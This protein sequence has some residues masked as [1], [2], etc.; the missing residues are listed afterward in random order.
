MINEEYYLKI[1]NNWDRLAKPLDS[2]G[3]FEEILSKI[4]GILRDETISISP[5]ALIVFIAD[6]GIINQGVSQS[7]EKVT[8][9]VARSIGSG[10]S[11]VCFMSQNANINVY[12]FNIGMKENVQI[13]G[14]DN[15][16]FIRNGTND[17]S[18]EPA[19]S[20]DELNK[21]INNGRLI[22]RSLKD[23]GYRVLL[24]G[25][26]GIGNTTTS[27][28]VISALLHMDAKEICGR[29]AG[30]SDNGLMAK[31][32]VINDA[33]ASYDLFEASG[34]DV[35]RTVGGLDIAAMVGVILE[36]IE[37]EIPVILDG[38]ITAAAALIADSID[39]R[40][41]DI[42]VFSHKGKESGVAYV[43]NRLSAKLIIDANMALG[44]GTGGV[45]LYAMLTSA[46]SVYK[47]NTSFSDMDIEQYKRFK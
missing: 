17:F 13:D 45:M 15:S 14:V 3:D 47:G 7:D 28:A 25:E 8:T 20:E 12:P 34:M 27:T 5:A 32:K 26:M 43:A 39:S 46:L 35:L 10:K 2:L 6:N 4:G 42:V 18:I 9:N 24:L 11:S 40:A 21:A 23:K 41:R 1:K 37:L 36:A 16:Y 19:L 29:G 38:L 22:A 44:E 30:L 33:I 31:I